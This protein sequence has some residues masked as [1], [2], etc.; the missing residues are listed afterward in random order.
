MIHVHGVYS[1]AGPCQDSRESRL[2]LGGRA[3]L[4]LRESRLPPFPASRGAVSLARGPCPLPPRHSQQVA[5][6]MSLI[7][8]SYEDPVRT[9]GPLGIQG[10]PHLRGLG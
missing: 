10:R 9:L 5:S 7:P 4:R 2:P 3:V 1:G 6:S 8:P